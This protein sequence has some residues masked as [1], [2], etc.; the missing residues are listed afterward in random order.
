MTAQTLLL[1][2]W[3][4]PCR[5]LRW[6][7]AVKMI[8]LGTVDVIAEYA[9]EI[10]SPSVTWNMP[11]VVRLRRQTIVRRGRVGFSRMNV[12]RRD[13]FVCQYCA[14]QLSLA[15]AT[16]DHVVPRSRG[17][18]TH[19]GNV[20]TACRPCNAR[21]A[22]LT[23]DEAGMFPLNPPC[24]PRSLPAASPVLER[25][26]VPAEWLPFLQPRLV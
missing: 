4:F 10:R 2:S 13:G 20:V 6:E 1:T 16:F 18:A 15:D 24:Q 11:A 22:N 21:K 14:R 25:R 8:Y 7:D 5:V 3:Y 19:F 23:C 26:T 9:E 12:F 17:G